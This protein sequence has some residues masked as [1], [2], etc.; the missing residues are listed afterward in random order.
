MSMREVNDRI[1]ICEVLRKINDRMQ[2]G[3]IAVNKEY[4]IRDML[5]LAERMA[6]KMAA[7]LREYNEDDDPLFW[8]EH[9]N[10][11]DVIDRSVDTYMA[12]DP[13]RALNLLKNNH[14]VE[15]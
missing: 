7:K 5:A 14:L 8:A 6:K 4:E 11:A 1:T 10:Y 2:G 12:G 15:T 9:K 3:V 13:D